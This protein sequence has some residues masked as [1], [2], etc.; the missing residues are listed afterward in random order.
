MNKSQTTEKSVAISKAGLKKRSGDTC[1]YSVKFF[2]LPRKENGQPHSFMD[3][4][5]HGQGVFVG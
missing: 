2:S 3:G 5:D 1:G 4:G